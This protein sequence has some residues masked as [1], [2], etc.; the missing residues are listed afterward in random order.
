MA[1]RLC[2]LLLLACAGWAAATPADPPPTPPGGTVRALAADPFH[3]GV[4]LLGTT[5][6]VLFRSSDAGRHWAFYSRLA[7]HDDWVVST[8]IADRSRPGRWYASLWSW[9][10]PDGGVYRSRDDG[11]TWQPLFLGRPV[12]AL[13]LAPSN[14]A[15][16]VAA[17]LDGVFRSRDAGRTWALISPPHDRELS[18]IESVAIDPT[19]PAEIY[20]GT[21][22]LPWRTIDGGRDWWQMRQGV[23]DDSD[24]F[25]IAVDRAHPTTVYLSACSGIYRSDDHG[26]QFRKIQGIPYSA[27]RTPA[28]VQDPAHP[29]TIYAGT[30]QGLWVT[31]DSGATWRR[32]TSPDL[33]VNAVLLVGQR[34]LLGTDFAGVYAS[35]DQGLSFHPSNPGF[36]SRHV[37]ALA[38]SPAGRYLAVTGDQA[39]GGIFFQPAAG[40]SWRQLPPL[41]DHDDANALHW[42]PRG[43]LAA[44]GHGLFLLPPPGP[45]P[46]IWLHPRSAPPTPVYALA[47]PSPASLQVLAAGQAGLFRSADGGLHWSYLR[48]APA[49]LYRLLALPPDPR[50][51]A[52]AT[53]WSRGRPDRGR[54]A[55]LPTRSRSVADKQSLA[56][57]ATSTVSRRPRGPRP[58][59]A[60]GGAA[61]DQA[62]RKPPRPAASWLFVAGAGYVL[63]SPDQGRH[64]LPGRLGL[65]HPGPPARINQLAAAGPGWLLA[66]T[67]RGLYQSHDN[68]ASWSLSGHGLPALDVRLIH[69]QPDGL[70]VLAATVG[71]A[72]RSR[73]GGVHWRP[74]RLPQATE[75]WA[76]SAPSLAALWSPALPAL[77][78]ASAKPH[79]LP[80]PNR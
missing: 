16:L 62:R 50:P 38:S 39:W 58:K 47:G 19:N 17:T 28:L 56:S 21:W 51:A 75:T 9:R 30:T 78:A 54:G 4:V 42:S 53:E 45:R 35:S 46:P 26:N 20:V 2:L 13:A 12:R 77:A 5:T 7:P 15:V 37:S 69:P 59:G 57:R 76:R 29:A 33:R 27:R 71:L 79:P 36:S 11:R 22:H 3:P 66:A 73:D 52:A 25:S 70:Y 74:V 32:I 44:T 80:V 14:H 31:H 10:R 23:I 61:P 34:I 43:L 18:N 60:G 49:P 8:L 63:R 48:A 40:G 72:F 6:G 65:D 64:F 68:G 67:S 41:P 1:R 24:V 55:G